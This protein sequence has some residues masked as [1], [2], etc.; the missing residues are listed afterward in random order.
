MDGMTER[1]HA[2]AIAVRGRAV[3]IRG[4]SGSGKSDLALRILARGPTPLFP[5]PA[6]LVA[7]DQ[8]ELSRQAMSLSGAAP[9]SI[10]GKIEVRGVGILELAAEAAANIVLVADLV[11]RGEAGRLP[12]PW[13]FTAL[14]GLRVPLVRIDPFE[15]AAP[16][17]VLAALIH[18]ALPPLIEHL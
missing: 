14:L 2:T 9:Q 8:V 17:K 3:L 4:P 13:P 7:D 16:E 5:E 1:V 12:D 6:R 15:A 18:P 10:A 11:Q